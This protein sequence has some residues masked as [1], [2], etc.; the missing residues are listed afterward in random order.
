MREIYPLFIFHAVICLLPLLL[1]VKSIIKAK[2]LTVNFLTYV[3]LAAGSAIM[4]LGILLSED[5][6]ILTGLFFPIGFWFIA[7]SIISLIK[8]AKCTK[9]TDA[10]YVEAIDSLYR[11]QLLFSPVF[12]Y[13]YNGRKYIEM[14]F[15][16]YRAK[17][18]SSLFADPI[19]H[20][21]YVHP[22][23]PEICTDKRS[24]PFLYIILLVLGCIISALGVFLMII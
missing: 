9:K 17:K 5:Q 2:Y 15:S 14:S 21:I 1:C 6:L 3:F 8:R 20:Q 11:G 23:H 19:G 18:L 16:M 4:I 12:R 24:F 22:K 7:F 10:R 13:E